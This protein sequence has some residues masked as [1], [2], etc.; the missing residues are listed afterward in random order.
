MDFTIDLYMYTKQERIEL[1]K[2]YDDLR[3]QREGN[4]NLMYPPLPDFQIENDFI[5]DRTIELRGINCWL[6]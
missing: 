5:G 4:P 1:K 3:R 6:K 2:K